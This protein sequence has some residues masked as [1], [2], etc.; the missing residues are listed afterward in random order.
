M[1]REK[2]HKKLSSALLEN[3]FE[4]PK[5][6][7]K[8]CIPKINGGADVIAI[9]PNGSGKS[10]TIMMSAIQKL[11]MAFEDAPRALIIV[12]DEVKA[13]EMKD[14]F[15]MLSK[16]TDLRAEVAFDGGKIDA[17]TEAIYFGTDIVIGTAK[18]VLE[19]YFRKNFNLNKIKLFV[20]D[21]AEMIIKHGL[22]GQIDRLALSLPKCQ[23]LVFTNDLT[24][25][26]EKLIEKFII[27]PIV[28][29]VE[30]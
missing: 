25:K 22:Q 21:D 30:E 15:R 14:Q 3:G 27:A 5:E 2:L 8:K 6:L 17:Q 13:L 19:I 26:I 9:G 20:I 7:Q 29:E 4:E 1:F 23:H 16:N 10:T 24:P 28:I 11:G 12:S 18:R